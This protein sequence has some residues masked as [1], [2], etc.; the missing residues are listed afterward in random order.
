MS[1]AWLFR[2]GTRRF[3]KEAQTFSELA[4]LSSVQLKTHNQKLASQFWDFQAVCRKLWVRKLKGLSTF[5]HSQGYSKDTV[6]TSKQNRF[7]FL[8]LRWR[9]HFFY[10]TKSNQN[11]R[12]RWT[13]T[14][15]PVELTETVSFESLSIVVRSVLWV[16]QWVANPKILLVLLCLFSLF[17]SQNVRNKLPVL[18][19]STAAKQR[20]CRTKPRNLFI[21][22]QLDVTNLGAAWYQY[23]DFSGT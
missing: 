10:T 23:A 3:P 21:K 11:S 19:T 1:C 9:T 12:P 2:F 20:V 4:V 14:E 5:W 8:E 22:E 7:L 13:V 16:L 15:D 18:Y 17:L 6:W